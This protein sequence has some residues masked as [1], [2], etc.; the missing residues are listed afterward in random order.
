MAMKML[1]AGGLEDRD[2]RIDVRGRSELSTQRPRFGDHRLAALDL[3]DRRRIA[4]S[5]GPPGHGSPIIVDQNVEIGD[6]MTSSPE[7]CGA[8]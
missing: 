8:Q 4:Q 1:E 2:Q 6:A 5:D 3:P 7:Q